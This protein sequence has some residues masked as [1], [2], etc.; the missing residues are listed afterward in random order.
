[1]PARRWNFAS[2]VS[3]R[4]WLIVTYAQLP[5][6]TSTRSVAE[7]EDDEDEEDDENGDAWKE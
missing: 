5:S 6:S 4:S 1:M 3:W 2:G 7:A